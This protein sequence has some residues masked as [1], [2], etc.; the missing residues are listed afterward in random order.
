MDEMV[1]YKC[2]NGNVC[3]HACIGSRF[4]WFGEIYVELRAR[5]AQCIVCRLERFF[6]R[7]WARDDLKW[8][9]SLRAKYVVVEH[10]VS[11]V[12]LAFACGVCL[13]AASSFRRL[14]SRA[15]AVL[16]PRAA[17]R[18]RSFSVFGRVGL[19]RSGR[20]VCFLCTHIR[21]E[22]TTTIH[23]NRTTRE[24]SCIAFALP[25]IYIERR[26]RVI[27]PM[28]TCSISILQ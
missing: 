24:S 1:L 3:L 26:E 2:G 25:S 8:S 17:S 10:V 6:G 18:R 22:R 9:L 5:G 20:F 11:C 14:L 13:C 28:T 21:T 27:I 19:F 7:R 4:I 23:W 15:R 12:A 16:L